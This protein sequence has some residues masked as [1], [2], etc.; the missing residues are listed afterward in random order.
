M[1]MSVGLH[2]CL[3]TIHVFGTHEGQKMTLEPVEL[4]IQRA[5]SHHG[6]H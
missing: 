2:V 5:V 4:K 1:C 6:H 3:Y